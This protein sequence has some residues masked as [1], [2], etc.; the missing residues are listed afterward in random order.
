MTDVFTKKKRSQIMSQI[1]G[2]NTKPELAVRKTLF[3][4]GYRFRLHDKTLPGSPDI[5]LKRIKTAIFVNGCFWHKH[6]CGK[7]VSPNEN[8]VFW[9]KKLKENVNRQKTNITKLK[10]LGWK[11]LILW[12]CQINKSNRLENTLLKRL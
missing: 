3:Q 5:V 10:L 6:D 9:S 8:P 4:L 2:K 1:S 11:P 12:E 7:N